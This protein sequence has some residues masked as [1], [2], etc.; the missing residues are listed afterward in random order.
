MAVMLTLGVAPGALRLQIRT[1]GHALVPVYAD[2]IR[3]DKEIR[4]E[5]GVEDLLV[6]LIEPDDPKG[7]FNTRTLELVC[8]L[9]EDFK[10]IEGIHP[11]NVFSLLTEPGDRVRPGT[12][13]FRTFLEVIPQTEVELIRLR[14]DLRAIELYTGTLVSADE[15]STAIM[16]GI[17]DDM[18][19]TALYRTLK[20]IIADKGDCG[21]EIHVIGAPVAEALLGTHILEDLGI[22]TAVLKDRT[23]S[24]DGAGWRIPHSLYDFRVL[25]ARKI[26]LVPIALV[27]MAIVFVIGFRSVAAAA[28][29]L[30]EVGAC[31]VFVFG[32]MG[33]LNVPVYLTIAVLPI[34][35][36]AIGVADEIHI[37]DRY[38]GLLRSRPDD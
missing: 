30:M 19:R 17:P 9:T 2:A 5:F 1:D 6:V 18:D 16:V 27:I 12:L 21:A 7:L 38:R 11:W 3:K 25:I 14:D 34:V 28:L 26:G 23:F 32:L 20:K 29:P 4:A 37:F 36:T 31:L 13:H 33:W 8:E 35:L 22:P 15:K 10:K 24:D